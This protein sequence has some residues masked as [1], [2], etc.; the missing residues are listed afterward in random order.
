[1]GGGV[2]AVEMAFSLAPLGT[3]ITML[4]HSEDILQ[5]EEPEARPLIREKMKKLGI[6]LITDFQFEK[7]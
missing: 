3:K 7:I 5:T 6:E 2:I 4:N 1:M